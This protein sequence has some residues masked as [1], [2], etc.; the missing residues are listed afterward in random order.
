VVRLARGA[1]LQGARRLRQA[2]RAAAL[3]PHTSAG[4]LLIVTIRSTSP[5]L[6][7]IARRRAV[8]LG[9]AVLR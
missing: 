4:G 7:E 5:R 1:D 3:E 6:R 8:P 9:E 2:C